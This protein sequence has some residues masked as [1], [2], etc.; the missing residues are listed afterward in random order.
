MAKVTWGDY[1]NRKSEFGIDKGVFYPEISPG[2]FSR[3]VAWNGLISVSEKSSG[4]SVSS[5][6]FDGVKYLDDPEL[7]TFEA[8]ITAY[9]APIQMTE[10]LGDSIIVPGI[11]LTRQRKKTFG[12]SYRTLYGDGTNYKIHLIYNALIVQE[13]SSYS[14]IS[15]NPDVSQFSWLI[16]AVPQRVEKF[17][18][19]PHFILDSA[20]LRPDNFKSLELILYG[21]DTTEPRLPSLD[22]LHDLA[23]GW[24]P[25]YIIPNTST[26]LADLID[27]YGDLHTTSN[28]GLN[29]SL[30]GTRLANSGFP[31]IYRLE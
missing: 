9:G 7:K 4:G 29:R 5:Y 16:S 12:L 10:A 21:T 22:E 23:A 30:I 3:G 31:G 17:V 18:P 19:S 27:Q 20:T 26:G 28:P 11:S 14:S 13:A 6:Y 8:S 1:T 2:E 25:I 15:D 24:H